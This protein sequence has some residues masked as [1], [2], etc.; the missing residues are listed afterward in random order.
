[1]V[2]PEVVDVEFSARCNLKCGFCFGPVDD[3][4]IP[5]L[6]TAFW[7]DTLT[8]IRAHGAQGIVVSGGEPT[9]HPDIVP[10]LSHAKQLGLSVVMS[11]HGQIPNRVLACAPFTDWI[12]IPIDAVSSEMLKLMRGRIWGVQQARDLVEQL[13]RVKPSIGIK[14]GT[15]ANAINLNEIPLLARELVESEIRIDTW[16]IYQYTARRQFKHRASEFRISEQKFGALAD[17]VDAVVPNRCFRIVFSSNSS[18]QRAY[19]F[20]YPDGSVG[21]PNVGPQMDDIILGNLLSEG[22]AVLKRVAQ[23]DWNNHVA[24]YRSTYSMTNPAT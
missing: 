19:L 24:N 1:M 13:R 7:F 2:F 17:M 9:I 20:I 12:A 18:R 11:T 14:L 21:I 22:T 5:D 3:R 8:S 4:T 10:L 15:V 23:I 16:K 6:P